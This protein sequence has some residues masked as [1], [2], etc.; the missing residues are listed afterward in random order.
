M[1]HIKKGCSPEFFE[2]WKQNFR[3]VEGK[4]PEYKD[5][6]GKDK[7]DLKMHIID[8]QYGLCCYCCK[9]IQDYNSHI[10]HFKPQSPY[11]SE[12]L[13]YFNLLVSCNGYKDK[14]ENCGH[15]KDNWHSEYYTISPLDENCES[16][17]TYTIDGHIRAD[18]NDTRAIE[19]IDKLELDIDLL[20]RA[21]RTAIYVSGIFDD[22]FEEI[23]DELIDL[24]SKPQNGKLSGFCVAILYCL[25]NA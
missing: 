3:N 12:V 5:L 20:Q 9:E 24:Y 19:T 10:E 21:R 15:K 23:K 18:H 7:H 17:F 4:E 22:N 2:N 13:N 1:R 25:L 6:R 14:R 11:D 16:F 8:E